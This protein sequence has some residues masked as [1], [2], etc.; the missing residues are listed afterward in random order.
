MGAEYASWQRNMFHG[1]F[2][3]MGSKKYKVSVRALKLPENQR[4]IVVC[5]NSVQRQ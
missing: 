5:R 3:F 2:C 4:S 1:D